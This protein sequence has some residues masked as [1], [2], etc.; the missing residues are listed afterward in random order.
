MCC[1]GI[2]SLAPFHS[3]MATPSYMYNNTTSVSLVSFAKE[4]KC[5]P[6]QSL[7]S[8]SS[9]EIEMKW[10]SED[11][12]GRIMSN[13]QRTVAI[14]R[15]LHQQQHQSLPVIDGDVLCTRGL[16]HLKTPA[17]FQARMSNNKRHI[18]AILD[19]QNKLSAQGKCNQ[20]S[21]KHV[22]LAMLSQALSREDMERAYSQA[23]LDAM[24]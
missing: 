21:P 4:V 17:T 12:R 18:Q 6:V 19:E 10:L 11:D 24:Q 16:E 20:G 14:M 8:M 9:S 22:R 1:T 3:P 5:I 23:A 7:N 13:L 2:G 15:R